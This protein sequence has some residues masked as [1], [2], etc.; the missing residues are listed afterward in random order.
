MCISHGAFCYC[1]CFNLVHIYLTFKLVAL[2]Y[3]F[4][5]IHVLRYSLLSDMIQLYVDDMI[6]DRESKVGL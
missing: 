6:S 4:A 1:L 3:G 5:L 2:K